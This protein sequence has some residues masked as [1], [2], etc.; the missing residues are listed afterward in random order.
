MTSKINTV[1]L[2]VIAISLIK[3]AFY[4]EILHDG[5]PQPIKFDSKALEEL[6]SEQIADVRVWN[7]YRDYKIVPLTVWCMNCG[8]K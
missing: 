8:N 7:P 2:F 3:V 4:N 5:A 6:S 1:L